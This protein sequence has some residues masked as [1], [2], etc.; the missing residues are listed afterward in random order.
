MPS[1]IT[2]FKSMYRKR[3]R[4]SRFHPH[5]SVD[6]RFRYITRTFLARVT[7]LRASR[8]DWQNNF[9]VC[10]HTESAGSDMGNFQDRDIGTTAA[11]RGNSSRT[12]SDLVRMNAPDQRLCFCRPLGTKERSSGPRAR[13]TYRARR[14][15]KWI[16]P[17]SPK[18]PLFAEL[19]QM[20]I[21]MQI[22]PA[23]PLRVGQTTKYR[24]GL[25]IGTCA[26]SELFD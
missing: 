10:R 19:T 24:V 2:S 16:N 11:E 4:A 3:A 20:M 21:H 26:V 12:N 23:L 5:S 14:D 17:N 9:R 6:A 7:G 15:A 22:T 25:Q 18:V 1:L 8:T 13:G